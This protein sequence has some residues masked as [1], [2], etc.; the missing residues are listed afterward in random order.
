MASSVVGKPIAVVDVTDEQLA[1]GM[2]AAGVP[3]P[4]VPLLVSFDAATRAGVLGTVTGD[5]E[6]LTGRKPAP[7][8][9]WF[10]ANKAALGA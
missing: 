8:K 10:E 9:A 2:K 1:E 4:I 3:A 5:V 7:L 6:K